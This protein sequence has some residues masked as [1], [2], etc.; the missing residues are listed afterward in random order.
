MSVLVDASREAI[1]HRIIAWDRGAD[2]HVFA[3]MRSRNVF[4]WTVRLLMW[5]AAGITAALTLFLLGY[6]LIKGLPNITWEL[7]ST[8]PSYLTGRIGILPDILNTV[9]IIIATLV[10]VLPLGVGAAIYLTEYATNKRVVGIIEYAAETL[11]GIPSIIYGLFG[12]LFFCN[13][14]D[15]NKSLLAGA[16]TLVIMNLPTVMRTTQESLKTVPQSYREG[17]FGLGAG[18]WRVI[19]TVVLPSC[20]DGVITGCILSVGRIVGESAA[21]LFTAGFAHALNGFFEG[22]SSSGA[23]LTVAL[24]VYATEEGDF[25]VAFAIAAILMILTL[26]INLSAILIGKYF[27]RKNKV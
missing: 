10:F 13:F 9:Y 4:I 1:S 7:L 14:M 27:E 22:L 20:V 11:S 19:R 12:T 16:L 17:A 21:L 25:E 18:K 26:L 3:E 6:V 24:Y 2:L 23:T 8:R 15:L 5:L